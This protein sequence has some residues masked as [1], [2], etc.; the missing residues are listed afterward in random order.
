MADDIQAQMEAK[1]NIAGLVEEKEAEIKGIV[2]QLDTLKEEINRYQISSESLQQQKQAFEEEKKELADNLKK[3]QK[4]AKKK[5]EI[6]TELEKLRGQDVNVLKK[7]V[8]EI[9]TELEQLREEWESYKKGATDE[10][11]EV[12]QDIQDKRIEYNYK[13]EKIKELKKE[14][15]QTV[16]EI[17][18]KKQVMQYMKQEWEA[19]PKDVN[20]NQFLK[21][22]N[23]II[24]KVK[25]QNA[26]IK[27]IIE[28]VK[29]L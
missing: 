17:E 19:L 23:E 6:I 1:Y 26:G 10:I 21:R 29:D 5:K 11:L 7:E 13:N 8:A 3:V 28:E 27:E 14:F 24:K 9:N 18:H 16:T 12:K 22:I 20:R 2:E 25:D 15:K 4:V